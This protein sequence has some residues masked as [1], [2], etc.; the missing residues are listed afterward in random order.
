[1][2]KVRNN[3]IVAIYRYLDDVCEVAESIEKRDD[4]KDH[5]IIS[6]TSYHELIHIAEKKYGIS[7][8][9]WFTLTG[10][11]TGVFTGF[12]M[13]LAMDYDWPLVV[14]GKTAGVYSLPAYVVFGFEL[15]I[16]L[17]AIATIV[18]MFVMGRFP[19]P[20]ATVFDT[21]TTDDRFAVFVPGVSIDSQQAK[22]LKEF[23]AEE[24][25]S[26]T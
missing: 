3:G 14:G 9:R 10:A 2:N 7:Q 11:L 25:Y 6:H 24:V 21:R 5:E 13:P 22:L 8:V 1:M 23:G 18:G 19:N 17:G 16:L 12:A 26:T 15:M 20:K 4:F